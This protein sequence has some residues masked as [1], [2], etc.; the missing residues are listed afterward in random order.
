MSKRQSSLKTKM[1]LVNLL[2]NAFDQIIYISQLLLS[3]AL[4]TRFANSISRKKEKTRS[5]FIIFQTTTKETLKLANLF[6]DNIE[7]SFI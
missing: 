5:R 7:K 3:Y 2:S 4:K 6:F 1:L